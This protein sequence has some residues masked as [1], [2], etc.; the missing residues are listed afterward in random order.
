MTNPAVEDVEVEA[1]PLGHLPIV[2]ALVDDL[3]I[4]DALDAL[5]PKD[6]RSKVSDADCVMAMV[7]NILGGRTALYRMEQW[8]QRLPV[9]VL[10]GPHCTP[11]D[12]NDA[13][14]ASTLD[15]L[16][17]AGT[18]TVLAAIVKRYLTREN[19][20]KTY[21]LHQDSTSISLFGAYE[22]EPPEWAPTPLFGFSKDHRPD[23][24]Q[25]VFGLTLHGSC[26]L[27][28]VST[29][30]DGNT[31]DKFMN[32]FH[33]ESLAGLLPDE[34]E[35]TLVADSK[36]VDAALLGALLDHGM[37][38]ISLVPRNFGARHA[39]VD[40]LC[41][42]TS[43]APELG[44]TPG[45]RKSDPDTLYRGRSY[46]LPFMVQH[47]GSSEAQAVKLRFLA[48][49][50]EALAGKFTASL[51][52]KLEKEF[53]AIHAAFKRANKKSFSCEADAE[54]QLTKL[55]A[56]S[57]LHT[58]TGQVQAFEIPGKR[59]RGRPRSDAPPPTAQRKYRVVLD[60]CAVDDEAVEKLRRSKSHLVLITDHLDQDTH[61]DAD[62]LAEYRH[63]HLV[64]GSCG[65]RWL[66]GPAQVAPVFLKKPARIAALG[67]VFILALMV[68]N[69]L[70][71]TVRKRLTDDEAT[72]PYYDRKKQTDRPTAEVVW[73]LFSDLVLV[74]LTVPGLQTIHRLQGLAEAQLRVLDMLE[75]DKAVLT[76]R[77]KSRTGTG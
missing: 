8:T 51:P 19:R 23:L 48:I 18:D 43:E 47:P 45:R 38:F 71:F 54:K 33:I 72:L 53:D 21:S 36:M 52:A 77:K 60:T 66:K 1:L 9:D 14:L 41:A 10:I 64:E 57:S 68:R 2:A 22:D 44:R 30:F 20:V 7:M 13:R 25:L 62:I 28:M 35:V 70:Q 56:A 74:V 37:H 16:F 24:K 31:S 73:E 29:M 4:T 65:F 26:G 39:A 5:L 34:D 69:Y 67:L 32:G 12:F 50:S 55:L 17:T 15:H 58:L 59:S 46:T 63:Q 76:R 75:L 61:S 6:P 27:P 40:R 3:G 11:E 42:E 49:H